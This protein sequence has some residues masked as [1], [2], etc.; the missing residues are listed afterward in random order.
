M[1]KQVY[2][3]FKSQEKYLRAVIN[4]LFFFEAYF[5]LQ[6]VLSVVVFLLNLRFNL[7]KAGTLGILTFVML[8][9]VWEI[10][11][12]YCKNKLQSQFMHFA[13]VF[14][15]AYAVFG[16]ALKTLYEVCNYINDPIKTIILGNLY[17]YEKGRLTYEQLFKKISEEIDIPSYTNF[18]ML[19]Y[20][21]DESGADIVSV[22]T[23]IIARETEQEKIR[24][25]L[26]GTVTVSVA[27]IGAMIALATYLVSNA[28]E[29]TDIVQQISPVTVLFTLVANIAAIAIAKMLLGWL[30]D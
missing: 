3:Y 29:T 10:L 11:V 28:L 25:Q 18:L 7:Y 20:Y 24:S 8:Y 19:I 4:Q 27:I 12:A 1:L 26:R 2:K 21:A 6:C 13:S 5:V 16:N 15:S 22:A 17:L 30:N 23:Q 9:F 14:A